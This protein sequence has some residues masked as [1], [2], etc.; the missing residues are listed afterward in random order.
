MAH[1]AQS[2]SCCA[3]SA[4]FTPFFFP[5][6]TC[7]RLRGHQR[8]LRCHGCAAA[9]HD[10]RS[11][12]RG[13]PGRCTAATCMVQPMGATA[14]VHP[15]TRRAAGCRPYWRDGQVRHQV[16]ACVP[17]GH[18]PEAS[19]R[20]QLWLPVQ[21][22][23]ACIL[24]LVSV[25]CGAWAANRKAAASWLVTRTCSGSSSSNCSRPARRRHARRCTYSSGRAAAAAAARCTTWRRCSPTSCTHWV[26]HAAPCSRSTG[27][28][29]GSCGTRSHADGSTCHAASSRGRVRVQP[30]AC[31]AEWR[32][33]ER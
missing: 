12:S 16:W 21:W 19:G 11:C 25:L 1:S 7:C 2:F 17:R 24:P 6:C 31:A 27:S 13:S 15:S 23:H 14:S 4:P 29:R 32:E 20:S 18:A 30:G 33:G 22:G 5:T 8:D 10:G 28:A 3:A 26:W 9:A